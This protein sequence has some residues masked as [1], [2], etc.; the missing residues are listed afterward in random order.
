MYYFSKEISMLLSDKI[1]QKDI[2]KNEVK[3]MLTYALK[4][5][6]VN[7]YAGKV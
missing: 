6:D 3:L 7:T 2:P 5:A 4:Y 1:I